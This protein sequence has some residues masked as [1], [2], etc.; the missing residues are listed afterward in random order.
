MG[1]VW[2]HMRSRPIELCAV[3]VPVRRSLTLAKEVLR[4]VFS[5]QK[6]KRAPTVMP[7]AAALMLMSAC[8]RMRRAC[9]R[10]APCA[11][12]AAPCRP[13]G[14]AGTAAAVPTKAMGMVAASMVESSMIS[15]L[16]CNVLQNTRAVREATR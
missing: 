16:V 15:I 12:A 14:T 3:P 7:A 13:P 8:E 5:G 2:V 1:A 9:W 6:A 10:E 11:C 4:P